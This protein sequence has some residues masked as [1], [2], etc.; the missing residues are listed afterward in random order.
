MEALAS[1]DVLAGTLDH[2]GQRFGLAPDELRVCL[3]QLAYAGWVA[4]QTQPGGRL[5]IRLERRSHIAPPPASGERRRPV[6]DAWR[7]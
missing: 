3:L 7:L 4:V 6:P 5:T 1:G 2:P